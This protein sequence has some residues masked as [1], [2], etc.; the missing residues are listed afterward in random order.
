MTTLLLC[1]CAVSHRC[2]G[3]LKQQVLVVLLVAV[4][5]VAVLMGRCFLRT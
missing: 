4:V 1:V 3:C 2:P 5:A